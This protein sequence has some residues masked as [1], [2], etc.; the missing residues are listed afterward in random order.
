MSRHCGLAGPVRPWHGI[1][2]ES[3]PENQDIKYCS[4]IN[5]IIGTPSIQPNMYLSIFV[6]TKQFKGL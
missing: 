2:R 1:W 5:T 6:S 4:A 3:G